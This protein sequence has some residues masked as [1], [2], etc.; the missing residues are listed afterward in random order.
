[1]EQGSVRVQQ[2]FAVVL[3]QGTTI[4]R[5]PRDEGTQ[6]FLQGGQASGAFLPERRF[7]KKDHFCGMG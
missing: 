3:V 6:P 4:L 5:Q 2:G 7:S 1:M